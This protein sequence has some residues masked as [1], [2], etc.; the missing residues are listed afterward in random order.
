MAKLYFYYSAMNAGKST[1]LLQSNYNYLERGMNTLLYAP[2][3]DNRYGVGE[4]TSRIGLSADARAI[5][6]DFDLFKDIE[7]FYGEDANLACVLIDEAQFLTKQQVIQLCKVVDELDIP[8][9]CYGIRSDFQAEPFPGS[10]YLLALADN[11]IEVK[12]VCHCGRKATM[13]MRIDAD[14]NKVT[15]GNQIAVGGNDMYVATCRLHF[16][17]ADSGINVASLAEASSIL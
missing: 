8:V 6:S 12:T 1:I 7:Q 9:L 2:I 16:M 11:L 17:R 5:D 13:N 3:V 15:E 10:L 14:G 4:I